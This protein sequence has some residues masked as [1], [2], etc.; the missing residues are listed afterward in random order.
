LR[1]PLARLAQPPGSRL[2]EAYEQWRAEPDWRRRWRRLQA[3]LLPSRAHMQSRYP[4]W[5]R[6]LLPLAY[7]IRALTGVWAALRPAVEP[8]AMARLEDSGIRPIEDVLSAP[9]STTEDR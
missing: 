4:G 9:V 6:A 3:T 8:V 1:E 7:P 5:P 2:R